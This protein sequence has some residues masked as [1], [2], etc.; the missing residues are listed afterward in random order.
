[1][2]PAP[3]ELRGAIRA[4]RLPGP[5]REQLE[6]HRR[7]RIVAAVERLICERGVTGVTVASVCAAANVSRAGFHRSFTDREDCLLAV[8][9]AI[10]QRIETNLLAACAQQDRWVDGVRAGLLSVL[11]FLQESPP[12]ARFLLAGAVTAEPPLLA[13]RSRLLDALA[14]AY[15]TRL[16]PA[17]P[18]VAS[19]P[20]GVQATLATAVSIIHSRVVEE[21]MPPLRELCGPSMALLVMPVLGATAAREELSGRLPPAPR[22]AADD[23]LGAA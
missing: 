8:F 5:R 21:P 6:Q 13:R 23:L 12:R 20:F 11:D 14:R 3:A 18:G 9:D 15:Y 16:P 1:M 7:E 4:A 2:T 10:E 22:R 17:P 19:T